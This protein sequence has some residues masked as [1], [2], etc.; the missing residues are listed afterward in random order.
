MQFRAASGQGAC[1]TC[2]RANGW[3]PLPSLLPLLLLL[4]LLPL[5]LPLLLLPL[6]LLLLPLLPS[7]RALLTL[8]TAASNHCCPP[9]RRVQEGHA[10]LLQ[11]SATPGWLGCILDM[12][13]VGNGELV[14]GNAAA[15]CLHRRQAQMHC[16]VHAAWA[17][18]S[19]PGNGVGCSC[20]EGGLPTSPARLCYTSSSP[21]GT[22]REA[23]S[24]VRDLPVLRHPPSYPA[25]HRPPFHPA[26]IRLVP[27]ALTAGLLHLPPLSVALQQFLALVQLAPPR[28]FCAAPLLK[29]PLTQQRTAVA[30]S[31][32]ELTPFTLPVPSV[33]AG[34][35]GGC[36][37]QPS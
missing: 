1:C 3:P 9:R 4:L 13:R 16:T 28:G 12:L 18:R 27:S 32:L 34:L 30:W 15:G 25:P 26:G 31:I 14:T 5:L 20:R 7:M 35:T 33:D 6:L 19:R 23:A 21:T 29:E 8:T 37:P 17:G 22:L 11:R 36:G 10:V 24:D 2:S